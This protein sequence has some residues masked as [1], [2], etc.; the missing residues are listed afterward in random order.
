MPS[1]VDLPIPSAPPSLA[2]SHRDCGDAVCVVTPAGEIDLAT[3]PLLKSRLVG[4][5]GEGYTRFVV[6]LSTVRYLDSTGLGV[7][8]AFSRRLKDGGLIAL[9]QA[10]GPVLGLLQLTGLD[11]R[12][13]LFAC[14][15]CLTARSATGATGS[16][17]LP[18][19]C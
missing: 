18:I 10:P 11:A 8:V 6:D 7:L 12:F 13:E 16:T 17:A 19:A 5:L 1:P 3:A 2:V 9:A 15:R 4:L 14:P